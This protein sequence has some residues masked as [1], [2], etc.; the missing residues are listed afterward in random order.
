MI[1][2]L[3]C[4]NYSFCNRAHIF[5]HFFEAIGEQL[6][7][8]NQWLQ[9]L[10]ATLKANE[11]QHPHLQLCTSRQYFMSMGKYPMDF[12]RRCS[13]GLEHRAQLFKDWKKEVF[14]KPE[15][16]HTFTLHLCLFLRIT[17]VVT[18]GGCL[19]CMQWLPVCRE[20]FAVTGGKIT[21]IFI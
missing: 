13:E 7:I 20:L 19:I 11:Q 16:D 5:K 4:V 12:H 2:H 21:F 6:S 3:F 18:G 8:L 1:I 15:S 9:C 17:N 14:R 10:R